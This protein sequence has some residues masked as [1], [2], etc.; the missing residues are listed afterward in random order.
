L[1][2]TLLLPPVATSFPFVLADSPKAIDPSLFALIMQNIVPT[3]M[4][5][6][7]VVLSNFYN[8]ESMTMTR[9]PQMWEFSPYASL[10]D[11]STFVAE[12]SGML[13]DIVPEDRIEE[14]SIGLAL[15]VLTYRTQNS[16]MPQAWWYGIP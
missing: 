9:A 13:V 14:Y 8:L 5:S 4:T 15:V 6:S 16:R 12:D 1:L 7:S 11:L 10:S 3:L 2:S